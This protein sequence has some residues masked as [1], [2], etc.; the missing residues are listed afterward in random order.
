MAALSV[1]ARLDLM[2]IVY[3]AKV[4]EI[5]VANV[6]MKTINPNETSTVITHLHTKIVV[7]TKLKRIF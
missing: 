1:D 3:C 7:G 6:A 2:D 5:N 4:L